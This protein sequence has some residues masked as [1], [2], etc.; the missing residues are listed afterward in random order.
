MLHQIVVVPSRR[1]PP[2]VVVDHEIT[3]VSLA[4]NT[5]LGL[6]ESICV[7]LYHAVSE[8]SPD[9]AYDFWESFG[10]PV[11]DATE[12]VH[13]A[14]A[15]YGTELQA[16]SSAGISTPGRYADLVGHLRG[17]VEGRGLPALSPDGFS[18]RLDVIE[19][20]AICALNSPIVQEFWNEPAALTPSRLTE[21]IALPE[22]DPEHR[23]RAILAWLSTLDTPAMLHW[24][25]TFSNPR[26]PRLDLSVTIDIEEL[27]PSSLDKSRL[28]EVIEQLAKES[29]LTNTSRQ[30]FMEGWQRHQVFSTFNPKIDR[31]S[32]VCVV[33]PP[34]EGDLLGDRSPESFER[35]LAS[36]RLIVGWGPQPVDSP[37]RFTEP[38]PRVVYEA[39]GGTLRVWTGSVKDV[40]ML[41]QSRKP[42]A[43][44]LAHTVNYDFG[45]GD[46]FDELLADVP[47]VVMASL[48][49]VSLWLRLTITGGIA[50]CS[51]LEYAV[52]GSPNYGSDY[53]YL[54]IKPLD[55]V[56]IMVILPT[57]PKLLTRVLS[58][59]NSGFAEGISAVNLRP[60]RRSEYDFVNVLGQHILDAIDIFEHSEVRNIDPFSRHR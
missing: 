30:S 14:V 49:F 47:H 3:H 60:T 10:Q 15:W 42:E 45:K 53:G 7:Y 17:V 8:D 52:I 41:I 23:F 50:G 6:F 16:G 4:R 57:L 56:D 43:S 20:A 18:G 46:F 2:Q 9:A 5:S 35:A 25:E 59:A 32:Q 38:H 29:G 51:A 21:K 28:V 39:H 12:M 11:H 31:Y 40:R 24:S 27:R 26:L 48:D 54:L 36:S 34:L 44:V 1:L 58:F 22:N 55:R 33:E 37:L 19:S 13:E